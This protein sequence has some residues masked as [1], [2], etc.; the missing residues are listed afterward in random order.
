[1]SEAQLR[2]VDETAHLLSVMRVKRS[3]DCASSRFLFFIQKDV[4]V[5]S[6]KIY[7][8]LPIIF[9]FTLSLWTLHCNSLDP[10]PIWIKNRNLAHFSSQDLRQITHHQ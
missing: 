7:F 9:Y 10:D 8:L 3:G 4:D 2:I 5:G 1:M 6:K